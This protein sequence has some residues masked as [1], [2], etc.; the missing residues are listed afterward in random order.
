MGLGIASIFIVRGSIVPAFA[1]A[2][3]RNIPIP[4][5]EYAT[6]DWYVKENAHLIK[7]KDVSD[8]RNIVEF[9]VDTSQGIDKD[10]GRVWDDD[11]ALGEKYVYAKGNRKTSNIYGSMFYATNGYSAKFPKLFIDRE[12]K[13]Y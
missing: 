2:A 11:D 4:S 7:N 13:R 8:L 12:S 5:V 3:S 9:T 6:G 1:D 10:T